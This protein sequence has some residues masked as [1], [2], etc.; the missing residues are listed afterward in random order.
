MNRSKIIPELEILKIIGF[1]M[2]ICVHFWV[3]YA[4][5]YLSNS[6]AQPV[7]T[8]ITA[9]VI[10]EMSFRSYFP[11]FESP[12]AKCSLT[13]A[14][15][16]F[17]SGYQGVGI[18]F[19][20]TG[21]GLTLSLTKKGA[22]DPWA[23]TINRF[24]RVYLPYLAILACL[25][26]LNLANSGHTGATMRALFLMDS[27]I[28][29]TW[30]L[31]PLLQVY[32]LI[33]F[34]YLLV[35]KS[36]TDKTRLFVLAALTLWL[37]SFCVLYAGYN[38]NPKII[39]LGVCPPAGIVLFRLA[40]P[41]FGMWLAFQYHDHYEKFE[42]IF[43]LKRLP[44][45]MALYLIGCVLSVAETNLHFAG[46]ILPLGQAVS[47]LLISCGLFLSLF[48]L[49]K[50]MRSDGRVAHYLALC[51]YEFYLLQWVPLSFLPMVFAKWHPTLSGLL[52]ILAACILSNFLLAYCAHHLIAW[53]LTNTW[54]RAKKILA[55]INRDLS[56]LP[57]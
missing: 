48:C 5:P 34:V 49:V 38:I 47:N 43:R 6:I 28:P 1:V 20:L 13:V 39:E 41:L 8:G 14:N 37:W 36:Q 53:I 22:V 11:S 7:P 33:P 26:C 25:I 31:F 30:F 12:N 24:E 51:G 29:Y 9:S 3:I 57:S 55:K 44:W 10:P 40:E 32:L 15:I 4:I 19:I 35:R 42:T 21:F 2:V 46:K 18:F 54:H 16:I 45:Y 17:S 50:Q 52:G 27:A 23:Y 56:S